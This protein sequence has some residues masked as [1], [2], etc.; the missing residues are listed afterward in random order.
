MQE[1]DKEPIVFTRLNDPIFFR[2]KT[3]V[4]IQTS[5]DGLID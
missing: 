2:L 3:T 1:T 4:N 5:G